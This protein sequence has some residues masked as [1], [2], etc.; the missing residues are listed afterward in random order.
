MPVK[1]FNQHDHPFWHDSLLVSK[2]MALMWDVSPIYCLFPNQKTHRSKNMGNSQSVNYHQLP[3]IA[4]TWVFPKI[5]VTP[6][7]SI[8]IGFSIIN[9]PF[10][11]CSPYFWKHPHQVSPLFRHLNLLRPSCPSRGT[12]FGPGPWR[13]GRFGYKKLP[14]DGGRWWLFVYRFIYFFQSH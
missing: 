12:K 2:S 5:R 10:C 9:H 4:R 6:K 7:S 1:L 14:K 11:G 3:F 8:L 13:T